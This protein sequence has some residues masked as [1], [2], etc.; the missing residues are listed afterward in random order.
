M[1]N[2]MLTEEEY[3][4]IQRRLD[5]IEYVIKEIGQAIEDG[6]YIQMGKIVR[7]LLIDRNA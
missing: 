5:N 1:I 2:I 7:D 6:N 4:K 3:L